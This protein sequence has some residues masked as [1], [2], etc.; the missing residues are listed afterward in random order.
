MS[1]SSKPPPI[2]PQPMDYDTG[3]AGHV[4][5]MP[6]YPLPPARRIFS[7]GRF[8][9]TTLVMLM[10]LGIFL[11]VMPRLEAAYKDFGAELPLVTTVMLSIGRLMNTPG[12]WFFGV[13]IAAS[14]GVLVATLPIRG[15]A[16]RLILVLS[17]GLIV[18]SVALAVFM[19]LVTM[20]QSISGGKR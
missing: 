8:I 7:A 19:P 15:R 18:L 16:L 20:M 11:V 2:P 14:T 1:G 9:M 10:L 12:G 3:A 6:Y 17:L 5:S 13:L 4:G